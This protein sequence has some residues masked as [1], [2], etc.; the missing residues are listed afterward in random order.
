MTAEQIDELKK[1]HALLF[2]AKRAAGLSDAQAAQ[3]IAAQIEHDLA[4]P[5]EAEARRRVA[6]AAEVVRVHAARLQAA[7]AEAQKVAD[8]VRAE[9]P[10][11]EV[12]L[13][14]VGDVDPN[15]I[16]LEERIAQLEVELKAAQESL[17]PAPK[18]GK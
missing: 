11:I 8:E 14:T 6:A 13:L 9:F 3:V 5:P 16:K 15:V 1:S 10:G 2:A 4:N 12:E 18:K 17:K 7:V